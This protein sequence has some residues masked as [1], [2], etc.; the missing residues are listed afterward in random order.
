MTVNHPNGGTMARSLDGRLARLA[1]RLQCCPVH[2][3]RLSCVAQWEWTGTAAEFAELMP[4]SDKLD[5]YLVH[6]R[7]TV[8]HCR[9]CGEPL[10]CGQCY[11]PLARKIALPDDLM[12]EAET[13]R[14]L[15]LMARMRERPEHP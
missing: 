4:L 7:P 6:L 9:R 3:V 15:E 12:T 5:P 1:E 11:E 14:Y 10:W 8:V 2:G 13:A